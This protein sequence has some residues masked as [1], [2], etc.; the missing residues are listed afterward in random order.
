M[1][2][3][4]KVSNNDV[5]I[6]M[7]DFPCGYTITLFLLHLILIIIPE[8]TISQNRPKSDSL[9]VGNFESV[10]G[11]PVTVDSV[12]KTFPQDSIKNTV[13]PNAFAFGIG[14]SWFYATNLN[15]KNDDGTDFIGV[16]VAPELRLIRIPKAFSI[17]ISSPSTL[18]INH[19]VSD[20]TSRDYFSFGFDLPLTLNLNF[21]S[22]AAP[23]I[24][25]IDET[26]LKLGF[27]IGYGLAY[28]RAYSSYDDADY[29]RKTNLIR[30]TGDFFHSAVVIGP[31][32]IRVSYLSNK[33][34]DHPMAISLGII[35][36]I[37]KSRLK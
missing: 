19:R 10:L 29:N 1:K 24:N 20:E 4:A 27:M 17:S 18:G 35:F 2:S 6:S 28:H 9:I 14:L 36:R 22:G 7:F 32:M 23:V 12:A 3:V 13:A 31:F 25:P 33:T 21:G 26:D 5:K 15:I 11:K 8:L 30:F 34:K 16:T 37:E